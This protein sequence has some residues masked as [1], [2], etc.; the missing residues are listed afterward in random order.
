MLMA[1]AGNLLMVFLGLELLSL[2]LY[3]LCAISARS[4]AREAALKYL[5][6]SSMAS[7]FLLYGSALLFGATGS[8]AFADLARARR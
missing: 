2:G 1:G 3:C 4:T 8:V 6:L 7:G 5:I